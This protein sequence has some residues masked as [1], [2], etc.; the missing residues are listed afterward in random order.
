MGLIRVSYVMC[1]RW[2]VLFIM[3]THVNIDLLHSH[4]KNLHV[5]F[6][7][8]YSSYTGIQLSFLC[9]FKAHGMLNAGHYGASHNIAYVLMQPPLIKP[10]D[11]QL[12]LADLDAIKV[13]GTGGGGIVQLVR[14]KWTSQF[15]ALKV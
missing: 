7:C 14:H 2:K 8:F 1:D 12:S 9:L 5:P 3:A 6:S 4:N 11:N 13:V 10:L 15:F